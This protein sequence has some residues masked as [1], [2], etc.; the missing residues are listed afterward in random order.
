MNNQCR[1]LPTNICMYVQNVKPYCRPAPLGS[2]KKVIS[3]AWLYL[4]HTPGRGHTGA[5][6]DQSNIF[7][8]KPHKY[9]L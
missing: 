6:H 1:D 7:Y 4:F 3:L 9:D 5:V 8:L 2:G